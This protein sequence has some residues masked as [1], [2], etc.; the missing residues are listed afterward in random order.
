[1]A[2]YL[3]AEWIDEARGLAGTQPDR[4]GASAR[5]QYVV[6]AG[7]EGD[8]KYWWRL[9]DGKLLES[10]LGVLDDPDF[11]MTLSY[12]D[13][14][15][16]QQGDLDFNSAF[17]QGRIKV[18]GDMGKLMQLMPLTNSAEYQ[19]LQVVLRGITQF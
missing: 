11:T 10:A 19:E 6:T 15:K 3:S 13:S 16:I 9:V 17:M 5:M 18:A 4:P 12:A 2:K 14:A 7:P 1:M 8:I